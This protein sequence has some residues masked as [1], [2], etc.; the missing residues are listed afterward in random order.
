MNRRTTRHRGPQVSAGAVDQFLQQV[1][2]PYL[3][4]PGTSS[5][6][7]WFLG[8]K[9]ENAEEFERLIV[10][11]IRDQAFWRRNFHPG[12]PT[13]VTEAVKR[14][15]EY[16]QAMGTL[17]DSYR[18]LLG[19]LKKS[20][21]FFSTRYQGH[22]NWDT[23]M[24]AVLGYFAAML[25]NP[26]NV[27]FEGSTAT[28]ILELLVGDDLCRMIG[29]PLPDKAA[30][31]AGAVRPWGHITS[32]GTVANIEAIWSARNLKFYPIAM[33]AALNE[34]PSL[35]AARD[36][37]VRTASGDQ[38]LLRELDVWSLCNLRGDDI[39]ALPARLTAEHGISPEAITQALTKV[40]PQSVGMHAF[41]S[42][43]AAELR[44]SPVILVPATKHYS[45]PK[46]A[47]ILGIGAAN[48]LDVPLDENARMS[49]P[50]LERILQA[51]LAERR[52][53]YTVVGVIGS[54]EESA[55]DPL[56]EI[57]A[58]RE[59]FRQK[60]LEFTVHADAAWGGY[61]VSILRDDD[62]GPGGKRPAPAAPRGEV[63][64]SRYTGEQYAVL[65]QADSVTVDPHK[66][67]YIPYP[68]G[69]L[70]YRNA[71][72]RD[73][74][75]F[76]APYILHAEDEP[77]VGI[78]GVE[79]SKPGAA[80]AAVFLAHKVI[81]P[82]RSGYGSIHRKALFNCRR[83]YARLLCMARP[84]DNFVV[85]PVPRLP[86]EI[87]GG[88]VAA[89]IE[90]IRERIDRRDTDELLSDDEAL[91]L[92]AEV[93]PDL[94]ILTYAFNFKRP[95]GAMNQS[96]AQA[97][98]LN[99]AVYEVLSLKP[100]EDPSG[101]PLLVTTTDFED[102][103]YGAL[104]MADYKRRLG[105]EGPGHAV[106]VLRSTVMNPWLTDFGDDSFLDMLEREFR[107][108]ISRAMFRDSMA[109]VFEEID[110]NNDGRLERA[111]IEAKLRA[112]GYRDEEIHEFLRSSDTSRDSTLSKQEFLES[113]SQLLVRASL[114]SRR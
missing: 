85:V 88:D 7:A 37:R 38:A 109:Q 13:L 46:A 54:T 105:V 39:L 112:L 98:R 12:D 20:M 28:T 24:P 40:S 108:A 71:A 5:P 51:C 96:L 11:A 30:C 33:Q 26:N 9:A 18:S 89:Q 74:V 3:D 113:Y 42:R 43:Y 61:H 67:G 58:L 31:Q 50:E 83:V 94:N 66:S 92:L 36:L 4:G 70:C 48:V 81:R 2:I 45:F 56:R 19:F 76:K 35:A 52:P 34:D 95:D 62:D 1:E 75:T 114:G 16:V 90:F 84:E 78:Y 10:E 27:A 80:V 57:L 14:Q 23:A 8:S 64:F 73:L 49:I 63:G 55:V 22:M 29:Y 32:G 93:G 102:A 69:A 103:H 59:Q 25:Y 110:A 100:G 65:H 6:E 104:F 72:M 86:A 91:A 44:G 99:K 79:G 111:E 107:K 17:T 82:S 60:G 101:H 106:T 97:N 77:S 41:F 21:P 15:P 47:A 68:A 53:V 87:T